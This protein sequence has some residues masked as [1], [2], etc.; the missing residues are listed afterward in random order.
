MSTFLLLHLDDKKE[1]LDTLDDFVQSHAPGLFEVVGATSV[2]EAL[3]HLG[4]RPDTHLCLVDYDLQAEIYPGSDEFWDGLSFASAAKFVS[5]NTNFILLTSQRPRLLMKMAAEVGYFGVVKKFDLKRQ[6]PKGLI[7]YLKYACYY[8]E[9]FLRRRSDAR[10]NFSQSIAHTLKSSLSTNQ[11]IIG[12][13]LKLMNEPGFGVNQMA[14][15][16]ERLIALDT[17]HV[18]IIEKISRVLKVYTKLEINIEALDLHEVVSKIVDAHPRKDLIEL[19]KPDS[20]TDGY[21]DQVSIGIA[22]ENL[23]DNSLKSISN[24]GSRSGLI[25]VSV[26]I[27]AEAHG[28]E[29]YEVKVLDNGVGLKPGTENDINKPFFTADNLKKGIASFGIGCAEA[30][31]IMML[32]RDGLRIGSLK[33]KD[34]CDGPGCLAILRFPRMSKGA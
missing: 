25:Q 4:D 13:A 22:L 10:L 31:K 21:F 11:D 15:V 34:R 1:D 26:H 20:E 7:E 33:V 19:L 2:E 6:Y 3:L 9:I 5:P 29:F 18:E 27:V 14:E 8:S 32:H 24:I 17:R 16:L 30:E 28:G 12:Q 23:I